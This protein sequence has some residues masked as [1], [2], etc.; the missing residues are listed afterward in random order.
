MLREAMVFAASRS[1]G[2]EV[3]VVSVSTTSPVR[4]SI[5]ICPIQ[6]QSD[7]PTVQQIKIDLLDQLPLRRN[8][9]KDLQL[10]GSKK[11]FR[12]YN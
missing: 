3:I 2:P 10:T 9:K 12:G 5:R 11:A 8:S 4:F 7:K 6:R 1:A